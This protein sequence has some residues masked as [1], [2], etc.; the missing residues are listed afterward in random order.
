MIN[1]WIIINQ[2]PRLTN[3][4][5]NG[6]KLGINGIIFSVNVYNLLIIGIG[7]PC[8]TLMTN[9]LFIFDFCYTINEQLNMFSSCKFMTKLLD[10]IHNFINFYFSLEWNIS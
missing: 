3:Y 9:Y 10:I 7:H 1:I 8:W 6:Y 5:I 2:G 4:D